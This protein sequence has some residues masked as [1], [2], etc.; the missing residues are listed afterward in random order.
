[1]PELAKDTVALLTF[2]LPGFLVAWVIYALTSIPKPVQLERVIQALVFTLF[3]KAFV[4]AEQWLLERI[5]SLHSVGQWTVN[6]E[7]A[8]SLATALILGLLGSWVA[9]QD[10]LHGYLRRKGISQ[11]SSRPS[12]WCDVFSKYQLPVT[13]HFKDDRRLFGWPEEWPSD[14]EKGHFFIVL[15]TWTH[16]AAVQTMTG[17][18]GILVNVSDIRLVEF[19]KRKE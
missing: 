9:N 13:L 15:P 10:K 1:M 19:V 3:V 11:R 14:P 17:V 7:L 5:G 18:E 16:E 12:E 8:A 6:S 2:L 4:A